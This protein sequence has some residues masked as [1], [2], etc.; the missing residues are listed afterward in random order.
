MYYKNDAP[1][2]TATR[3]RVIRTSP[4]IPAS[5]VYTV[6]AVHGVP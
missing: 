6:D 5:L 4:H 3:M 2:A 1:H